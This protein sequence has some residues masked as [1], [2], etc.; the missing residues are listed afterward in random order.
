[1]FQIIKNVSKHSLIYGGADLLSKGISFIMIPLYTHYLT[2]ADYG[3]M[4]LLDLTSWIAG[5]FL[6]MGVAQALVRYYYEFEDP[7]RKQLV[8]SVAA[9]AVVASAIVFLVGLIGFSRQISHL[10]FESPDYVRMFN[11]VFITMAIGLCNEIPLT[12]IR[13]EQKSFLYVAVNLV[14]LLVN[15]ALNI[16]FIVKFG[17]GIMGIL[18]A[19]LIASSL[20]ALYLVYYLLRSVKLSFSFPLLR[21]MLTYG[22]PLMW[23]WFGMFVV[24]FGDRFFLQRL[25]SLEDVGIYSLAY[26]FGFLPNLLVL[27][28]FFL[29]WS[30]K[31]FELLK[32]PD[33][34]SI[35]STILTYFMLAEVYI[36]LGIAILIKDVIRLVADTQYLDAY[37]YVPL[38]LA[39]YLFRG[40]YSYLEFGIHLEKKTRHLAISSLVA[41]GINVGLNFLLIP[42]LGLW[43]AVLATLGT[44]FFLFA[45]IYTV[46]Q[47]LYYIPCQFARLAK[48]GLVAAGLYGISILIDIQSLAAS[49]TFKSLLALS[50]PLAL[51]FVGFYTVEERAKI[52][53]ICRRIFPAGRPGRGAER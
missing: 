15:L 31:R 51:F 47:K 14:R 40:A 12:L 23:S 7:A 22:F 33:A 48:I 44:F 18:I 52:R 35:F 21:S 37:R 32:E 5:M 27:N 41:A 3:T 46:S 2:P 11:I 36:S 16:L 53:E 13:I 30:P 49:L 45:Y 29:F 4:E 25:T 10:I 28:P 9:I 38:I 39:A 34:K 43:G 42:R 20:V 24:N 6:A 17:M 50:F 19:S 1:M 26:K 8:V